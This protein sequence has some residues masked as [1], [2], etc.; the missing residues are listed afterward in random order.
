MPGKEVRVG[1]NGFGVIGKRVAE[2]VTKQDD[3][4]LIGISDITPDYRVK[5][6]QHKGYPIYVSIPEKLPEMKAAGVQVSG[7]LGDLLKQVDVIVDCTPA[8][9]GARNK[10]TYDKAGVKSIFQGGE[11]HELT[12]RSFVA[13]CNYKEN[14]GAGSTRV[15]SCNTTGI[16][17][18]VG[19]LSKGLGIERARV[20]LFRRGTDPW[21]SHK[22]GL[23]NT[24]VPEAHI[25]SHQGPDAKTVLHDLDIRTMAARGPFNIGHMHFAMIQLKDSFN[26]KDVLKGDLGRPR[27]DMWEVVYWEDIL[28]VVDGELNMVYQVHNESIVVPENVDAIRALTGVEEDWKVSVAATDK[29]LG[30]TH[31]FI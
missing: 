2:A 6:G 21:E 5:M 23:I 24:V 20:V 29:S 25:P 4:K 13:Q 22:T 7:T 1:V 8:G 18:V 31:T 16:C 12:G 9:I 26:K 17:R 30:I 27:A 15:V 11:K 28:D 3:M 14:L 10:A 19:S